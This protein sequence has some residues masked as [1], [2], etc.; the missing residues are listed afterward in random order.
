MKGQNIGN[1]LP[2]TRMYTCIPTCEKGIY[3]THLLVANWRKNY[4]M[5]LTDENIIQS[6]NY[7]GDK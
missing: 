3:E 5:P 4:Q 2:K 7:R 6:K 1:I